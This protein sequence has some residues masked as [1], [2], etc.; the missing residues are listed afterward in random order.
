MRYTAWVETISNKGKYLTYTDY[1][2]SYQDAEEWIKLKSQKAIAAGK[3][4]GDS[5]VNYC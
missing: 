3:T 5:G 4:I 1:F 2:A